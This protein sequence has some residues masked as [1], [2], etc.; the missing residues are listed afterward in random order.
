MS[1]F[2][3]LENLSPKELQCKKVNVRVASRVA[4]RLKTLNL[5]KF[6]NFYKIPKMLRFDGVYPAVHSQA[7]F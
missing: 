7:K 2:E 1:H 3:N 5:R 4:E 6:G